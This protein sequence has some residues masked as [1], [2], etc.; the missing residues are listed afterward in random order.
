MKR[1]FI[2]SAVTLCAAIFAP[3]VAECVPHAPFER[4]RIYWDMS[5]RCVPLKSPSGYGRMIQLQDGRLMMTGGA[6]NRGV[7]C[8]FSSDYGKTWSDPQVILSNNSQW[9]MCNPDMIQLRDGTLLMGINPRPAQ[10][11]SEDRPYSI[12]VIRSTDN[13]QTWSGMIRVHTASHLGQ[14]GCWEPAFLE[15]PSGEVHCY[16]SLE[17][18]DSNDQEIMMSRSFDKGL[19]WTPAQRVSYRYGHRDGM[20]VAILTDNG[21]IVVTI[22][23]NGQPGYSGFRATSFRCTLEQNWTNFWVDAGSP[24]RSKLLVNDDDLQYI[25]A[26]PYIRKLPNGETVASW[27]GE[28]E[29]LKNCGIDLY[30]HMVAV[31]DA[32]ARNFRCVSPSF[33]VP[34]GGRAN[35]GSINV[36]DDGCVYAIA[37]AYEGGQ[38]EGNSLIKGTPRKGFT[39]EFGTPVLD[40]SPMRDVY[41]YTAGRQLTMGSQTGCRTEADFAYDNDNLYFYAYVMDTDLVTD[42]VDRDGIFL[43][44]DVAGCCDTYPQTGMFRFFFGTDGVVM[45]RRGESNKWQSEEETA[46]V[47]Y[48]LDLRKRYY[49]MEVAIPWKLLGEA[50]APSADRVM[51]MNMQVRDRRKNALKFETIPEATDKASWTWPELTLKVNAGVD[52]TRVDDMRVT[53]KTEG[54]EVTAECVAGIAGME[55]YTT[56]GM[57]VAAVDDS[58]MSLPS[59]GIYILNI[60]LSDGTVVSRLTAVR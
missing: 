50:K 30:N 56:S 2:S 24:N 21:E 13:G 57:L 43:Y 41:G 35:W 44:L 39:A 37:G 48:V 42:V 22:E 1:K 3:T 59:G 7:E 29:G 14:D 47:T 60:Q 52:Y 6:W 23:D 26:G 17:L 16:F 18:V 5:T 8:T 25:S 19:T 46:D 33:Y 38:S 58:S 54:C 9:E 4:S 12:D 49:C 28:K 51:R 27:M 31:G 32:D 15:L 53:V 40:A 55:A 34:E 36:A 20:P 45:M 11:Y 10:P